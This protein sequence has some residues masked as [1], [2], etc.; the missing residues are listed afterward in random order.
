MTFILILFVLVGCGM[1]IRV[2]DPATMKTF[3]LNVQDT[4]NKLKASSGDDPEKNNSKRVSML[5][6]CFVLHL[7]APNH[8]LGKSTLSLVVFAKHDLGTSN[9]KPK[10]NALSFILSANSL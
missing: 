2:D 1:K 7:K 9:A 5:C 6:A 8:G 4:S 10:P 3:I